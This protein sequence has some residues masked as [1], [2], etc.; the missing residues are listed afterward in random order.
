[1]AAKDSHAPKEF[2]EGYHTYQYGMG[3]G[4]MQGRL[5]ERPL[6]GSKRGY[7]AVQRDTFA[8]WISHLAYKEPALD[9][10]VAQ[11]SRVALLVPNLFQ[12][13]QLQVLADAF[14]HWVVDQLPASSSLKGHYL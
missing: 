1:M 3:I 5:V 4:S 13:W 8:D 14:S 9:W 10:G 12:E 2:R 6:L 11:D 7:F